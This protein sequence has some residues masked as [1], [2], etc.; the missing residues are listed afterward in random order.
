MEIVFNGNR[1][2]EFAFVSWF[3]KNKTYHILVFQF[4]GYVRKTAS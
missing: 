1:K 3:M 2:R 4:S